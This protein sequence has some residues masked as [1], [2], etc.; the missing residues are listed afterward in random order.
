MGI[1]VFMYVNFK[2]IKQKEWEKTYEESL[3]LL[4]AFPLPLMREE[5][6][7]SSG[8]EH[9]VLTR[10][11]VENKG[12]PDEY[13]EITGDMKSRK[14][15]E[16]FRLYR[17]ISKYRERRNYSTTHGDVLYADDEN[18]EFINNGV[19]VFGNKTQGYPFHLAVLSV[20]VLFESRFPKNICVTGDINE[21][22]VKKAVSLVNKIVEEPVVIPICMDGPRLWKR[23]EMLY[24]D[25]KRLIKRFKAV[26]RGSYRDALG[27]ILRYE[28]K[29][30]AHKNFKREIEDY[31]SLSQLGARDLL[32]TWL[33]TTRDIKLLIKLLCLP[34]GRRK[35]TLKELLE[36]VCATFVN[37]PI[38]ERKPLFSLTSSSERLPTVDS[39][40]GMLFATAAG[41]LKK[42]V[43]EYYLSKEELLDVFCSFDETNKDA[44]STIIKS[45]NSRLRS[46]LEKLRSTEGT[47]R[48]EDEIEADK[49]IDEL[50]SPEDIEEYEEGGDEDR[51][52]LL[53]I[54]GE[55]L[56]E[57]AEKAHGLLEPYLNSEDREFILRNLMRGSMKAGVVLK[58]DAWE[59]IEKEENLSILKRLFL[60]MGWGIGD[61][62][63]LRWKIYIFEHK[64]LWE[65]LIKYI[66]LEGT[67]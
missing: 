28:G 22:Q 39:Q 62:D 41:A 44:F 3:K 24:P 21:W 31:E 34:L 37:I 36:N 7:G 65:P 15:A 2:G 23:L 58:E 11:I 27:V 20:G 53:Q 13:W 6:E 48:A 35:F 45:V 30:I 66:H 32:I 60:L 51:E 56:T 57:I 54:T 59:N 33:D 17:H 18:I 9:Y 46:Y 1:C 67:D 55:M 43:K 63:F 64:S 42:S 52:K 49:E 50:F 12:T 38:E 29:S 26:Y 5:V 4:D 25:R 47:K 8:C 19:T 10:N 16:D 40:I 14:Y 61:V